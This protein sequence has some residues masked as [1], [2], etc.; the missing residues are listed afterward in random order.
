MDFKMLEYRIFNFIY[1]YF[2][3]GG[4]IA[5][6]IIQYLILFVCLYSIIIPLILFIW[7]KIGLFLFSII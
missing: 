7:Y 6:I 1:D 3:D 5:C 4:V 2:G